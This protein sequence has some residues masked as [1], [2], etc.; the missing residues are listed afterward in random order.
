MN[1]ERIHSLIQKYSDNIATEAEKEELLLWY[2]ETAYQDVVFPGGEEETKA[3][4][5]SQINKQIKPKRLSLSP[6]RWLAAA[7]ILLI[8]GSVAFFAGRSLLNQH[9]NNYGAAKKGIVV[10][11]SNK[12][13]LTLA[14]G[15]K[16]S[17]TDATNGT[18]ASQHGIQVTKAANGQ[19]IYTVKST[20]I[21][22]DRSNTANNTVAAAF[23]TIQ[24]PRGGQY[25]VVLPDGSR[26]WLNAVSSLRFPVVF[27]N[28]KERQVTLTGEGYFEVAHNSKQP[29]KVITDKQVVE[30]LGTHFDIN[31]YADEGSTKTSLLQGSVRVTAG[32]KG[33]VLRPG[34][35]AV[36]SDGFSVNDTGVKSA[37]AWKDGYFNFDDEKLETIMRSVSRW[38]NVDVIF[39]D[40]ALKNETFGA[41]T[42]RFENIS[43]LLKK[44]EQ[45]GDVQFTIDGSTIHIKRKK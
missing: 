20:P 26:V 38:Y 29:F 42:N 8:L 19:I 22:T 30:V 1:Q 7:S 35:Q 44:M 37:V 39:E 16:I 21:T 28:P 27:D 43:Q 2:R 5:L 17:L 4:M 3:Y 11:G 31:A 36:L 13:I 25:Q 40:T 14:D 15:T 23:N 33:A 9:P 12:A 6:T 45:T 41:V 10:P 18:I 32:T 24:T 34:Q